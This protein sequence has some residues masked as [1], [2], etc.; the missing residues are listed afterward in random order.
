M[1]QIKPDVT[2]IEQKINKFSEFIDP[3][4]EG[5]A[6]ISFSEQ[7]RN[8][9]E[10]LAQLMA[11][12]AGHDAGHLVQITPTAM[13]FVP[14]RGG[15]SHCAEEWTDFEHIGRGVELLGCLIGEIDK[16]DIHANR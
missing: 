14:S 8:A 1:L 3:N 5:F 7:Y 4:E 15:R 2:R 16:G 13:I 10:Y 11:K 9:T 12:E 6:R